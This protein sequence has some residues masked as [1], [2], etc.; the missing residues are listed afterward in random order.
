MPRIS[1]KN[2]SVEL[3]PASGSIVHLGWPGESMNW[4]LRTEE[5]GWHPGSS[6]W[7]LGFF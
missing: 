7:G 3:C 2:F 1:N 4:V 6:N 5:S